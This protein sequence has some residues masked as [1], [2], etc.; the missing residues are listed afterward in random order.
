MISQRLS[1]T[2]GLLIFCGLNMGLGE[3]AVSVLDDTYFLD[4]IETTAEPL[5]FTTVVIDSPRHGTIQIRSNHD[6]PYVGPITADRSILLRFS[7]HVAPQ[8]R[9]RVCSV[10]SAA[11]LMVD[12]SFAFKLDTDL[13]DDEQSI[14]FYIIDPWQNRDIFGEHELRIDVLDPMGLQVA[15]E[16]SSFLYLPC[17]NS[18]AVCDEDDWGTDGEQPLSRL[19]SANVEILERVTSGRRIRLAIGQNSSLVRI[20]VSEH[21]SFAC[22]YRFAAFFS[23]PRAAAL[24][25]APMRRGPANGQHVGMFRACPA[26]VQGLAELN[27][28]VRAAGCANQFSGPEWPALELAGLSVQVNCTAAGAVAAAVEQ[29]VSKTTCSQACIGGG[30]GGGGGGEAHAVVVPLQSEDEPG[31]PWTLVPRISCCRMS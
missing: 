8:D 16:S 4:N 25:G 13:C 21:F 18:S 24:H 15:W 3:K 9:S 7:I 22:I 17:S 30:G 28:S 27:V 19:A 6:P 29:E 12:G 14:D 23:A 20:A 31:G 1:A 11:R 26:G 2:L 5:E 10:G